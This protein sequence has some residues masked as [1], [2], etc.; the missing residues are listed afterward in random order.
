MLLQW[1]VYAIGTHES[2][3]LPDHL[4][5]RKI[6]GIIDNTQN[7]DNIVFYC[8]GYGDFDN[9]CAKVCKLIKDTRPNCEVVFVTPYISKS[10]QAISTQKL[11]DLT[12]YPPL[13]S[14]PLKFAISKRNEWM[15]DQ[16]DLV[17]AYIDHTYGGAYKSF[18]YAKKKK[19]R[20][21]NLSEKSE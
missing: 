21:I 3:N 4:P 12:M 1:L 9:L 8:G 20:V 2:Y 18:C 7:E 13:E 10:H 17:I 5:E 11:Y 14:V 15:I 16:A 6:C 19:K